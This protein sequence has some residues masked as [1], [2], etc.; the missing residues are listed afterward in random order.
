MPRVAALPLSG[1]LP[2]SPVLSWL[3]GQALLLALGD[4]GP[5]SARGRRPEQRWEGGGQAWSA[6]CWAACP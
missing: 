6:H 5:V 4:A 3:R 1:R 2:P